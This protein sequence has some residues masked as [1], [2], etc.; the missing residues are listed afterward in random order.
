MRKIGA[1][2]SGIGVRGRRQTLTGR[3]FV[4]KYMGKYGGKCYGGL[5]IC[6]DR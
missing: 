5:G 4:W 6:C 3:V 1:I 2:I